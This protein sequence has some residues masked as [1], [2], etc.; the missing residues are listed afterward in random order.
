MRLLPDFPR[1]MASDKRTGHPHHVPIRC[2]CGRVLAHEHSRGA[3]TTHGTVTCPSCGATG[4]VPLEDM[5][6]ALDRRV[7][8][9]DA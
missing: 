6:A 1:Q 9:T 2:D 4:E 3:G 7:E 8:V 5:C